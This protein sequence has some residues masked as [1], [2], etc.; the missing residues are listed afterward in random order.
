MLRCHLR[1]ITLTLLMLLFSH[2][3]NIKLRWSGGVREDPD[4]F[5]P[6]YYFLR[7]QPLY[8]CQTFT[9]NA[10]CLYTGHRHHH[11]LG[12]AFYIKTFQSTSSSD[13]QIH[14]EI[15]LMANNEM[16]E[17]IRVVLSSPGPKSFF[18]K[19]SRLNPN[20][21][22]NPN[23]SSYLES[24]SKELNLSSVLIQTWTRPDLDLN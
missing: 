15:V 4:K 12:P 18:P 5:C 9:D 21:V 23:K 20:P 22:L 2:R 3:D 14:C 17:Q 13:F 1:H 16:M 8:P 7:S 10:P 6:N 11:P 24:S 19:P